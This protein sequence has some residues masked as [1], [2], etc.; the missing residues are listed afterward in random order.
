MFDWWEMEMLILM[1][2]RPSAFVLSDEG[3]E[4]QKRVWDETVELLGAECPGVELL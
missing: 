3:K 4:V 2:N 1:F